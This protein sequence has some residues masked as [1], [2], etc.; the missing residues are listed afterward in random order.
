ML[1]RN[2][3][4]NELVSDLFCMFPFWTTTHSYRLRHLAHHQY[5]N[6]PERDPDVTQMVASGHR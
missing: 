2:R 6:D 4:L 5:V 1:F 3:V